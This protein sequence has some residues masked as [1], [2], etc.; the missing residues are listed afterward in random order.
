M[1]RKTVVNETRK[2][3]G[4]PAEY[5]S[6]TR[7]NGRLVPIDSDDDCWSGAIVWG[8]LLLALVPLLVIV[9]MCL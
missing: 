1:Q 4:P 5:R 6:F 7:V 9:F 8:F 3:W 2:H